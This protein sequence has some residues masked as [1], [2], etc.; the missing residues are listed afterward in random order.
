MVDKTSDMINKYIGIISKTVDSSDEE[1]KQILEMYQERLKTLSEELL[2]VDLSYETRLLNMQEATEIRES[3][4]DIKRDQDKH[5]IKIIS[6]IGS[7]IVTVA[8]GA[9]SI[10][11]NNSSNDDD[12]IDT[13][14]KE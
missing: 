12:T 8:L 2:N 1:T 4:R 14:F 11:S 7:A 13:S 9:I 10:L 3:V 6:V 5:R